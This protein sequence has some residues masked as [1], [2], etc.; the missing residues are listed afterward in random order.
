MKNYANKAMFN[1]ILWLCK[2]KIEIIEFGKDQM[3][4]ILLLKQIMEESCKL[5][6]KLLNL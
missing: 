4:K 5:K 1:A 6:E 2:I 3:I